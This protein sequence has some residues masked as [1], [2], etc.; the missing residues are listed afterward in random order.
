MP[1]PIGRFAVC[2]GLLLV[3]AA[4]GR[5]LAQSSDASP[6]PVVPEKAGKELHAFRI[7]GASPRID[8]RLDDE[9][10]NSAQA[11]EDLLQEDPDNMS[12]PTERT[13]V[14]F[15]YDDRYLYIAARCFASD[16]SKIRTGLG[17]RDNFPQSDV[18]AFGLD[19]RHDHLTAYIFRAN[20][21]GVQADQTYFDDTSSNSDYDSVWEVVTQVTALGWDA[22]FRI[23]FSQM[24]FNVP[25]GDQ[26][27]WGLQ[28]RRE[29]P[30]RGEVDRWVP[31][32]RGEQGQV[33]RYGHLI[34][35]DRLTPPRRVEILPY[36]LGRFEKASGT[37]SEQSLGAGADL[38][39]GIGP[40]A[41][42]SATVN[43]D[44]G[45]VEADPAVLNLS[46]FESFFP[47]K[48]P[49]FLEDSRIFVLPYNQIPDFYSRRIGQTPGRFALQSNETLVRK[50]DNTTIIG[51]A[52]LTGK[53]ST[54]TYGGLTA[55]TSREYA[56]VDVTT[57][58]P[59][60]SD[61]V[62]REEH[63]IEPMTGYSVGRVQRD[64]LRGS[65][66]VG[67]IATAVVR[68][69]DADA[70]TGGGDYNIR[71]SSNRYV[72]N[73]HWLGTHAPI[74]GTVKNGFG[75]VTNFSYNGKYLGVN[76][77]YDHIGS[78]F[79]NTDLGFLS[80]RT[81]KNEVN[82]GLN[83]NQ[84]DPRKAFRAQNYFVTAT[85]R[86]NGDG[87]VFDSYFGVGTN[88]N[89]KN[90]WYAYL[91]YFY[92]FDR[93]DDL[94]TRGGPPIVRP[95]SDNIN[96]GISTDSRKRWGASTNVSFGHDVQGGWNGF[97]GSN[98]RLQP[99]S[100]LQASI[101]ASYS[102]GVDAAQWIKNT[103]ADGD[104]VED[105]VYG[106]LRRDVVNITA[107][108]TYAF[109]RDMTLEAFLQPF[110]AVGTYSNIGKLARPSSFDFSPVTLADN[111]DFNRKSLRST[112]VL[113]W[114]YV[115]GS[116]LFFVWNLSTSDTSR[117]G[118]FSPTRDLGSAFR[119]PGTNV[120]AIKINYWLTP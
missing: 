30:A 27:V 69:R 77:H 14:Q 78:T 96:F 97:S 83:F 51:A 9:V 28:V 68:E 60:G 48:R 79:R 103:D 35:D 86:W 40:S 112:V 46:I 45:Q 7:R 32:P 111:P 6:E 41:T 34:F 50:P 2:V 20:A 91:N 10:W 49:F 82:G 59:D 67:A 92:N 47:E 33:S 87:L 84:P 65:S 5:V 63:V 113:R 52:K 39:I 24:R 115:R 4:G 62:T 31:T 22:E 85:R 54:W 16:P 44:F 90:Y 93:F 114:E 72:W 38:R 56:T 89:F 13:V 117:A 37:S 19:P 53:A 76:G 58:A 119:A 3:G 81:D 17:R 23:P 29:I 42:L 73:G 108:T 116:T 55:L 61:V 88:L 70:F 57:Q 104:G 1:R 71:W 25:P 99:S 21:S 36:T 94:D 15:A 101:G 26:S 75:G 105:N 95:K 64:I 120:F 43:P 109:S 100:R 107:R 102:W 106:R 8:G 74:S 66:T 11:I 98:L 80:S 118:V 110:V 18:I 12:A